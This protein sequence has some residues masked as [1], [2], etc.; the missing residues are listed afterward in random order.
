MSYFN[1]TYIDVIMFCIESDN[2]RF[3]CNKQFVFVFAYIMTF[4]PHLINDDTTIAFK[5]G[6]QQDNKNGEQK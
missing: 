5:I 3:K 6:F 1:D 4:L 2:N